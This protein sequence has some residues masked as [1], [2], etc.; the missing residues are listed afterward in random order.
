MPPTPKVTPK[1]PPTL[2]ETLSLPTEP[3]VISDD[4]NDYSFLIHGEKKIGKTTLATAEPG[5][6]VLSFDPL[7]PGLEIMQ[8]HCPDWA[9]LKTYVSKLEAAA[10]GKFPYKRLVLDRVD[11]AYIACTKWV[12]KERG[13]DHPSDEGYARAWHALR[14]E[15]LSVILRLLRLPCG[16]WFICHSEWK[17]QKSKTGVTT[18]KLVPDLAG[19]AEEILNGLVDGWFAY[20]YEGPK[21][22]L[23]LLG[24]ATIGAGHALDT[25]FLTP[26]GERVREVEMGSSPKEAW[27]AFLAAFNNK[28]RH[29]TLAEAEAPPPRPVVKKK[30]VK[31]GSR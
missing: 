3:S 22:I 15:F 1:K 7:R 25:H 31:H 14:D 23:Y 13:I 19:R 12:C 18:F 10:K 26:E 4:L 21:R 8:V 5:V 16:T 29:T 6:L 11:L 30:V 17:E 28:Q 9:H 24:D 20:D 27:Q 2:A